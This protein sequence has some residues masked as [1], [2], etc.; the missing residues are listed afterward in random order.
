MPTNWDPHNLN[1]SNKKWDVVYRAEE[2]TLMSFSAISKIHYQTK[3]QVF[4]KTQHQLQLSSCL[5]RSSPHQVG[6]LTLCTPCVE[7]W[8]WWC[9][10]C[11]LPV[12]Y[13]CRVSLPVPTNCVPWEKSLRTHNLNA[14]WH[15]GTDSV[16]LSEPHFNNAYI[17]YFIIYTA[18]T[19]P[20]S[21]DIPPSWNQ[22]LI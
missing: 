12:A 1:S 15:D 4:E 16:I 10:A 5:V 20:P 7:S 13:E 22:M 19:T 6:F 2:L 11:T 9:Q 14:L 18:E 8:K 21:N 17:Y 3:P